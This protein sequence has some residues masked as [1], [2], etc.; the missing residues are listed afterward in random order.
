MDTQKS[1]FMHYME[2]GEFNVFEYHI[3][4]YGAGPF[5]YHGRRGKRRSQIRMP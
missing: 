2:F 1:W 4:A 5:T 3:S